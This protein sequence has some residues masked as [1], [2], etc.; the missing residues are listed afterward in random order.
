MRRVLNDLVKMA[1]L[2]DPSGASQDFTQRKSF[3]YYDPY[4]PEDG[5]EFASLRFE[6]EAKF[7]ASVIIDLHK[8]SLDALE[9]Q[10]A[11]DSFAD[12]ERLKQVRLLLDRLKNLKVIDGPV[13]IKLFNL[14][15]YKLSEE[16]D[17]QDE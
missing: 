11:S 1:Q 5:T 13:L 8:E 6:D 2:I 4:N 16:V 12:K 15:R 10:I 3:S 9:K 17:L 7:R 14:Y